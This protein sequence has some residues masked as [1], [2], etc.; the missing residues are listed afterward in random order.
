L[1]VE[2]WVYHRGLR[3]LPRV[4]LSGLRRSKSGRAR[5]TFKRRARQ[6]LTRSR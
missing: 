6:S 5:P 1:V 3:R 2:W 4:T